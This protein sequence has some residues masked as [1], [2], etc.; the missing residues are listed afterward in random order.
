MR[1]IHPAKARAVQEKRKLKILN[2]IEKQKRSCLRQ[3]TR[4]LNRVDRQML[5]AR[6]EW[7]IQRSQA[8]KQERWMKQMGGYER[9]FESAIAMI[10]RAHV[11]RMRENRRREEERIRSEIIAEALTDGKVVTINSSGGFSIS[12][13][14]KIPNGTVVIHSPRVSF[15]KTGPTSQDA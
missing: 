8:E 12:E 2:R 7:A 1:R 10:G 6:I 3:E 14:V 5:A 4:R 15:D 11:N 9:G 13:P